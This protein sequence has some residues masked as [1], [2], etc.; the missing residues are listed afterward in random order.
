MLWLTKHAK[1]VTAVGFFI[2]LVRMFSDPIVGFGELM[3]QMYCFLS[4]PN[5]ARDGWKVEEILR[6]L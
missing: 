6:F 2:A 1:H 4:P 5:T 3:L